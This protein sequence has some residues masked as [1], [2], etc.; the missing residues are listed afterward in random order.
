MEVNL[1]L[2]IMKPI[3]LLFIFLCL[4]IIAQA[5][6]SK[7]VNITSAGTLKTMLTEN[8]LQTITDLTL[9]GTIDARDFKTMRDNMPSL[10]ILDMGEVTVSHYFGWEGTWDINEFPADAIPIGAFSKN[11]G[12][13]SLTSV[14]LP[15]SINAILG[16][17]FA[18]C[19]NLGSINIPSTVTSIGEYAFW[20]CD[21]LTDL[22]INSALT[23]IGGGAFCGCGALITVDAE[24]INYTSQEGI[25]FNKDLTT[26]ISLPT[27]ITGTYI[28]PSTVTTIEE[29]AFRNCRL[30]SVT[31]PISIKNIKYCAFAG[32]RSLA[33]VIVNSTYPLDLENSESIFYEVNTSAC[34]LHVPYGS[35]A[36]YSV[37][38]EWKGF[39]N[40]VEES[41]GLILSSRYLNI[42]ANGNSGSTINVLSNVSWTAVSDQQWLTVNPVAGTGNQSLTFIMEAN[43]SDLARSAKITFSCNGYNSQVL[44]LLQEGLPKTLE[45]T[46]GQ[47]SKL[48]T[49]SE[50]NN[51]SHLVLSGTI[52]A[53]DIYM[54]RDSMPNLTVLDMEKVVIAPYTIS[55]DDYEKNAIP[56][57]AFYNPD[58]TRQDSHLTTIILPTSLTAIENY[59]FYKCKNL[60]T[61]VIPGSVTSIG[62]GAFAHCTSLESINIPASIYD[63]NGLFYQCSALINVDPA[64]PYLSSS[65]GVLYDKNQTTLLHCPTSKTGDYKIPATV[66]TIYGSA[67]ESCAKLMSVE[68]PQFVDTLESYTF[69]NCSA[70]FIVNANNKS[71]S[72]LDGILYNKQKTYLIKCPVSKTGS[73]EIP[74]SVSGIANSA[75]ANCRSLT[76]IRVNWPH[77]IKLPSDQWIF[78]SFDFSNC[79]LQVPFGA[80]EFYSSTDP[81]KAFTHMEEEPNGFILSATLLSLPKEGETN[82]SV[83]IKTTLPW[84]ANSN[85]SW[86][87]V[88]PVSG[89]GNTNLTFTAEPNS[90]FFARIASITFSAQGFPS[91]TITIT[92]SGEAKTVEISAGTLASTFTEKELNGI[93]NLTITGTIDARDFKTMR[94]KMPLLSVLDLSGATIVAYNGSEG[95]LDDIPSYAENEIPIYAF[96]NITNQTPKSN[97]K[98]VVFP[99]GLKSI[100]WGAFSY[101]DGL[102]SANLP[103]S[104]TNI[105]SGAFSYCKSLSSVTIPAG[106][107]YISS[108]AFENCTALTSIIAK[109]LIPLDLSTMGNVFFNVDHHNCTLYVPYGSRKFYQNA[110]HWEDFEHIV[111][112][113]EGFLVSGFLLEF[114]AEEASKTLNIKATTSW[115][116]STDQTWLTI[117]PISGTGN[118]VLTFTVESNPLTVRRTAY[119]TVTATNYDSQKI[120]IHQTGLPGTIEVSAGGLRSA[121]TLEELNNISNLTITGTIDA[122]DFKTM[123]DEMPLLAVLDISGAEVA[124]Y[125]GTEGTFIQEPW[126]YPANEIPMHAFS[127]DMTGNPKTNLLSV[128]LPATLKSMAY[129][130][131]NSCSSLKTI[132]I[133]SSVT[134]IGGMAF[135]GCS[136]L[137]SI[138]LPPSLTSIEE[139]TFGGCKLL[140]DISIPI[141]VTF[142]GN[143]AFAGCFS[144]SSVEIPSQV[145][146]IG[147]DAFLNCHN[148]LSVDMSSSVTS[149]GGSAFEDCRSLTSVN[150]PSSLHAIKE[151]TFLVCRELASIVIPSS[152]TSI[153]DL[154]FAGCQSLSSVNIPPMVTAIGEAAFRDCSNLTTITI[155][156]WVN[157][158]GSNAFENCTAMTSISA[159]PLTPVDL[160]TSPNVFLAINK[161][162]C[163]LNVP[164]KSKISY[165]SAGQWKDFKNIQEEIHG[166]RLDSIA[167]TFPAPG[168]SSVVNATANTTWNLSSDQ[169][170]LTADPVSGNGNQSI[171]LTAGVNATAATRFAIIT[172]SA[173]GTTQKFYRITQ[174]GLPKTI[175]TIAGGLRSSLTAEEL[176]GVT[177]LT[178]TGTIDA[179][180]FKTMRDEMPLLAVLD[181]SGATIAF[182]TGE[183]GTYYGSSLYPF[184]YPANEVPAY[185]FASEYPE[186]GNTSLV[187]VHLPPTV[188][189]IREFAFSE[190]KG[191]TTFTIPSMVNFIDNAA[192]ANCSSLTTIHANASTPA[193]MYYDVFMGVDKANCI[194]QVP[195]GSKQLYTE[196]WPWSEFFQIID[197][198]VGIRNAMEN[199]HH[200]TCYP[201]PFTQQLTIEIQNPKHLKLTVDIYNLAGQRIKN[202]ATGNTSESLN[203]SWDGTNEK[204]Q[205]V[206]TGIYLC[207]M[208]GQ[209]RQLV[210][211]G[212][213]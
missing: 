175:T 115:T 24:N 135:N 7:T 68:I 3:Y 153:G 146:S 187:S 123:R 96:R 182:Y 144:L 197:A 120:T 203:L 156:A 181:L 9:T 112:D 61:L 174:Q 48:M 192:F 148:L 152:V 98:T 183:E 104:V 18:W 178:I 212:I 73:I 97:L 119:V 121:F 85:Q 204:G 137:T 50:L 70:L 42:P 21:K 12:K 86:L 213:K 191:L 87:K 205:R 124:A 88:S 126:D 59:A 142:I 118:Q 62:N 29:N 102:I 75:F 56:T 130:S 136:S 160:A 193:L 185:A 201:N 143:G 10:S 171:T 66:K 170:W 28:I 176:K 20:G 63:A 84:S 41:N 15:A 78:Y 55:W 150:L 13:Y 114:P 8:E 190:C 34:I 17:A 139:Y 45:A 199:T 155:P 177:N 38:D 69:E 103:P 134:F 128:S 129:A 93:V 105:G 46:P 52:D 95:T 64:N 16:N 67:F 106:I 33:N 196:T 19:A 22:N 77:P 47:L 151:H 80:K 149:I 81:W 74:Y 133:P 207:K 145:T 189:A 101:C 141:S 25:L 131:F 57:Y 168:G 159:H 109:A 99:N 158:I 53:R 92:Q 184:E 39:G 198:P 173:E 122:R 76:S 166:F 154:A 82:T 37:A 140:A 60:T 211:A 208:N 83:N 40:I 65:D 138:Q 4:T 125:S 27:S 202:L 54:I 30:T 43:P 206:L 200:F 169:P 72:A 188:T 210:Y 157:S 32:C 113:M 90:T 36:Y 49:E 108:D 14:T 172:V 180:D 186:K 91:Q 31:I 167:F 132:T 194:L 127:G 162:N 195:S 117:A 89:T 147:T 179:R 51:L 163:T 116:I 71:Y 94:D 11:N 6:V 58:F 2:N 35:K 209:T 110:K 44:S 107:T 1:K 100:S 164:Y 165:L 26:L 161:D 5:Q 111:E 23:S 79:T